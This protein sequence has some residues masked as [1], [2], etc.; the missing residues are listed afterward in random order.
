[1][2]SSYLPI[3]AM[4][5][6]CSFICSV[7]GLVGAVFPLY[8][9]ME[10]G[11]IYHLLADSLY[12]EPRDVFEEDELFDDAGAM[13]RV[14]ELQADELLVPLFPAFKETADSVVARNSED[15]M[16]TDE[17]GKL[18]DAAIS[19]EMLAMVESPKIRKRK[20]F[21]D[22]QDSTPKVSKPNPWEFKTPLLRLMRADFAAPPLTHYLKLKQ[23]GWQLTQGQVEKYALQTFARARMS[24]CPFLEL[25]EGFKRFGN[26]YVPRV[27]TINRKCGSQKLYHSDAD[28]QRWIAI[29]VA[30]SEKPIRTDANSVHMTLPQFHR[31][32]DLL[33]ER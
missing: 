7:L 6:I 27:A 14:A 23:A 28:L 20:S 1:M 21:R 25:S 15:L 8:E 24:L 31:M 5:I 12:S 30:R 10:E 13:Q 26:S 29:V 16:S 19:G 32:I 17:V 22:R 18:M 9:E 4:R 2:R 11:T 33:L 3:L